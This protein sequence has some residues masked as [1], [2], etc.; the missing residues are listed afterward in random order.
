MQKCLENIIHN[1]YLENQEM[2]I[3]EDGRR[4]ETE[5][6]QLVWL[7]QEKGGKRSGPWPRD[8]QRKHTVHSQ[9]THVKHSIE[10]KMDTK[11]L[12]THDSLESIG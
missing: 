12:Q 7:V 3:R 9:F 2:V 1:N 6:N 5:G 11:I 4:V 8:L 10:C